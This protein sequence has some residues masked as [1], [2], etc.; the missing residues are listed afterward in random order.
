M[1]VRHDEANN[2]AGPENPLALAQKPLRI[3][4]IKMFENVGSVD[5]GNGMLLERK[6]LRQVVHQGPYIPLRALAI[7]AD[8]F[9]SC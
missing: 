7:P 2:T 4:K 9:E 8:K 5:G 6:R 3:R 1:K